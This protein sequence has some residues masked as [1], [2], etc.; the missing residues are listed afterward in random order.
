MML[1]VAHDKGENVTKHKVRHGNCG[2]VDQ[3]TKIW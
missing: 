2:V 1:R 3:Q